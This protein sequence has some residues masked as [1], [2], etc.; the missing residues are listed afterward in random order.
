MKID[1]MLN[2]PAASP[3]KAGMMQIGKGLNIANATTAGSDITG[4]FPSRHLLLQLVRLRR[5]SN[6]LN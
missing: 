5:V 3:L 2:N 6:K 4:G 1:A